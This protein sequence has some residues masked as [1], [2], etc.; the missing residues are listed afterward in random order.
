MQWTA[1]AQSQIKQSFLLPRESFEPDK[2]TVLKKRVPEQNF[3]RATDLPQ[4]LLSL[5]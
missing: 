1:I 2:T 4:F 5:Q 3:R